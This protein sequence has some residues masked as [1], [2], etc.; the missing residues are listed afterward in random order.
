MAKIAKSN[1]LKKPAKTVQGKP[2]KRAKPANAAPK[3]K[4]AA[5]AV[6]PISAKV[7]LK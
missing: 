5:A 2:V 4:P 6:K 3:K 7:K 1:T